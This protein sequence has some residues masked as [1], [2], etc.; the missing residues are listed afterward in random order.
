MPDTL[1]SALIY[2]NVCP[3]LHK[4]D[5]GWVFKQH[6]SYQFSAHSHLVCNYIV[7]NIQ[8]NYT[9]AGYPCITF[10]GVPQSISCQHR[11][12]PTRD[13][14]LLFWIYY[15]VIYAFFL[16]QIISNFL[17]DSIFWMQIS[18]LATCT[19]Y[20]FCDPFQAQ[21][22]NAFLAISMW[23]KIRGNKTGLPRQGQKSWPIWKNLSALQIIQLFTL[24]RG[25]NDQGDPYRYDRV[26]FLV[27]SLDAKYYSCE[28]YVVIC[29]SQYILRLINSIIC[30]V[31]TDLS[32]SYNA[33]FTRAQRT[34]SLP[35][36][37]HA[38]CRGLNLVCLIKLP[39]NGG[40]GAS[41]K[42][43]TTIYFILGKKEPSSP[44]HQI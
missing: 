33:N 23:K 13:L 32:Y 17:S 31:L 19:W 34:Q 36:I 42:E 18:L 24:F 2:E 16:Y 37:N 44:L 11:S 15:L 14:W 30:W 4:L 41:T 3:F 20:Q 39:L 6:I 35:L 7:C 27:V 21:V 40:I 29:N 8:V 28:K 26:E 38:S 25:H 9:L 5:E 10:L 12:P 43:F 22:Q 1:Y